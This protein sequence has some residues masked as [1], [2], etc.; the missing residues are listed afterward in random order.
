MTVPAI[1]YL[2]L[3]TLPFAVIAYFDPLWGY[4]IVSPLFWWLF[5]SRTSARLPVLL[6]LLLV[7]ATGLYQLGAWG[8][9][10]SFY[11]QGTGFNAL[12]FFHLDA[13]SLKIAASHFTAAYFGVLLLI[14][15]TALLSLSVRQ[16][17]WSS[18]RL[19]PPLA[20]FVALS[21]YAP[22]HSLGT[23]M[24]EQWWAS[25]QSAVMMA[26]NRLEPVA[27]EQPPKNLIFLYLESI[28]QLYM[29]EEL[30]PALT[31]RLNQFRQQHHHYSDIRQVS[32][33]V[34]FTMGG[35]VASQCGV[36]I[37]VFSHDL[38]S[39]NASL[40]SLQHPLP[41]TNCLGDI[42][43]AYGY[44]TAMFKGA[45]LDFS[46]ARNFIDS[47]GFDRSSGREE[48]LEQLADPPMNDW[49][50]QD[51]ALFDQAY[52][53]VERM[54]ATGD[55]YLFSLVTL[56]THPPAG[57]PSGRCPT[58]PHSDD[59]ML[60][61]THCTD[62]QV[63]AFYDRLL[64]AGLME[65]SVLV[66]FSD[67]LSMPN[68]QT[69]TLN[70]QQRRL[71]FIVVG[72]EPSRQFVHPGSHFDITPTLLDYLGIPGF[73]RHNAGSTL[74]EGAPGAWFQPDSG[75]QA[76]ARSASYVGRKIS[77]Q[78]GVRYFPEE[79]MVE[80]DNARFMPNFDGLAL[81]PGE[82]Y[83]LLFDRQGEY[84]EA[85]STAE[86]DRLQHKEDALMVLTGAG[87]ELTG[88]LD[89]EAPYLY[90]GFAGGPSI[91]LPA[92]TRSEVTAAQVRRLF[93]LEQG[94]VQSGPR[95]ES[96]RTIH[97]V[98]IG[99]LGRI[100]PP[101][102]LDYWA[103]QLEQNGGNL[104][105]IADSL[106]RQENRGSALLERTA[107]E[108]VDLLYRQLFGRSVEPAGS[109]LY[110]GQ[111][112]GS[113]EDLVLMAVTI[114]QGAGGGDARTLESRIR[115]SERVSSAL[116]RDGDEASRQEQANRL[117][118]DVVDE[119]TLESAWQKWIDH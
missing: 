45:S 73:K 4:G 36:P 2:S 14:L 26:E 58:Y 114:A 78:G 18:W 118:P 72:D 81:S 55:P 102:R 31:P 66:L 42:L 85:I 90:V 79:G 32:D 115:F 71:T 1:L 91:M 76:I 108:Q 28:E 13:E 93:S 106:F 63:G 83:G 57:L 25:Q 50:L 101:K 47:H 69:D 77:I 20:L 39:A 22:L 27:L 65:N 82:V 104:I 23:M 67:H 37:N 24:V 19:S 110:S 68:T 29:D 70:Q 61:A 41:N 74:K 10:S 60:Q 64:A 38:R 95:E 86:M 21:S 53:E 96:L 84:L 100:A 111:L 16:L 103:Q 7:L 51:E 59:P 62:Y 30:Y 54:A 87:S 92:G 48:W 113:G 98:F 117:L 80:V 11:T 116:R 119:I 56:G 88:L 105:L 35:V 3:L 99:G 6:Q 33:S 94:N 52:G 9:A 109:R 8:L 12:F 46:G 49:G 44:Q 97:Q 40:G 75:A 17:P 107:V 43:K 34:G 89:P 112:N 5:S 15:L